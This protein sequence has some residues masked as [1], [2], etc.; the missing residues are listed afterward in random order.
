LA[1]GLVAAAVA[2]V[3]G[4]YVYIH[5]IQGKAPPPLTLASPSDPSDPVSTGSSGG[6]GVWNVA[7]GSVV[8]YRVKEVL[9][10]QSNEAVGRTS[11]VT[12]SITVAGTTVTA[13][14]FTVDLTTAQSDESRR[15]GQFNGR[16]METATYP[17]STFALT[18]PIE[19]GSVPAEGVQR[20]Y[21][22]KGNLS[23]HGVTR[24]VVFTVTG[25]HTGSTIQVAG[26]IPV[27]FSDY[28]IQNPSFGPVTTED[29]GLLEFSLNFTPA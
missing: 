28:N 15:D 10:G 11:E 24:S 23:L 17:T 3:G 29:H 22:A 25:R 13:G 6:D 26:S 18:E 27:T 19:V 7:S 12:G 5:F 9:S 4:P 21:R 16:I 8:G 2:M 20:S 14:R 1:I